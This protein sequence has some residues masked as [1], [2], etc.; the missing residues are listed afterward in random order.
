MGKQTRKPPR[1]KRS[2][3]A[4]IDDELAQLALVLDEYKHDNNAYGWFR[5]PWRDGL[6]AAT[7]LLDVIEN[8]YPGETGDEFSG[9]L[10][11]LIRSARARVPVYEQAGAI[12]K[13]IAALRENTPLARFL[14]AC[15]RCIQL[16]EANSHGGGEAYNDQLLSAFL[17]IE[18]HLVAEVVLENRCE[19]AIGTTHHLQGDS[20]DRLRSAFTIAWN[21]GLYLAAYSIK[22]SNL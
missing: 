14:L 2:L 11:R 17:G 19:D 12:H 3:T 1:R 10:R 15:T 7:L 21:R 22:P 20:L 8:L 18:P 4:P 13:A 5:L 6:N 9:E 16:R